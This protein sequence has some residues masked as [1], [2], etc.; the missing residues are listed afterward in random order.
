M[1]DL[2]YHSFQIRLA[3]SNALSNSLE[4]LEQCS[5]SKVLELCC[6][7]EIL[8]PFHLI[9]LLYYLLKRSSVD[10]LG[11]CG[12]I[13]GCSGSCE[14]TLHSREVDGREQG[15]REVDG[16]LAGR[17]SREVDA[18]SWQA[19]NNH[20]HTEGNSVVILS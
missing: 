5:G 4:F 7:F 15:G 16:R 10:E 18:C 9:Y 2:F 11:N 12:A 14:K 6:Y 3:A 1:L 20:C 8:I 19:M 17:H 13:K